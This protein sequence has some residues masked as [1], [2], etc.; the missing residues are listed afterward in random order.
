M[1]LKDPEARRAYHRQYMHNYLAQGSEAR[2]RHLERVR[3][4]NARYQAEKRAWVD[5]YLAEHP[6]V[7]CGETDLE[8][9]DF[10]HVRGKKAAAIAEAVKR[11]GYSLGR[12]QAEVALCEVRCANCH[13]RITRRRER[14]ARALI[15]AETGLEP[16]TSGLWAPRA[17]NCATP[18]YPH[19]G[20]NRVPGIE[21]P[22]SYP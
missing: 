10:D 5:A 13:R 20:S 21:S 7:D 22:G 4:N 16:A 12:L 19:A 9:L 15:V 17:A 8:V 1:P 2:E 14:E 11:L 18:Q 6:C 3:R